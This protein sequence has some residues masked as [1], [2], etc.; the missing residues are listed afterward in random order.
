M[1]SPKS[2][3]MSARDNVFVT[4]F[5]GIRFPDINFS[6]KVKLLNHGVFIYNKCS[7]LRSRTKCL[8]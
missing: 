1:N 2:A 4:N 5:P 6:T 8:G 3:K 7:G